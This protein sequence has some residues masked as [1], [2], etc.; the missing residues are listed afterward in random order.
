MLIGDIFRKWFDIDVEPC[1]SCET[2]Q[3]QLAIVNREKEQMLQSILSFSK[4]ALPI[5]TPAINLQDVRPKAITWN[6]R[7]QMLEAE[8]RVQAKILAEQKKHIQESVDSLEKELGIE[9]G[10]A[11]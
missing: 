1:R 11:K 9:E 4:P 7:R 5:E 8:D 2:L 3:M 10:V 6:V